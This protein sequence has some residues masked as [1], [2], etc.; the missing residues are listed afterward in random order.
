MIE[1]QTA[2]V[3]STHVSRRT[4]RRSWSWNKYVAPRS[5]VY[6]ASHVMP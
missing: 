3:Y 2:S 6:Y 5:R 4:R 1:T